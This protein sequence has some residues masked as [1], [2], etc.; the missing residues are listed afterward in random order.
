MVPNTP[1]WNIENL[2]AQRKPG[3][4]Q[5]IAFIKSAAFFRAVIKSLLC[6][7]LKAWISSFNEGSLK[8]NLLYTVF[9][10]LL[11]YLKSYLSSLD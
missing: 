3:G 4:S 9:I 7:S 11:L 5:F 10:I 8:V 1:V 2:P 6:W